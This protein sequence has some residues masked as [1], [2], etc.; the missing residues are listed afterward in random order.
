MTDLQ[1]F[2]YAVCATAFLC[3]AAW[4]L[5][6]YGDMTVRVLAILALMLAGASQFLAQSES[7]RAQGA[8]WALVLF[9]AFVFIMAFVAYMV[10]P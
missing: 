7:P 1:K 10:T 8:A 2:M 3:M 4:G 9:G 5:I 6:V